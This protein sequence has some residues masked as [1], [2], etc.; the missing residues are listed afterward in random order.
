MDLDPGLSFNF[1]FLVMDGT[2]QK[3]Q[4]YLDFKFPYV[5][6]PY[7]GVPVEEGQSE[8]QFI[9]IPEEFHVKVE[10]FGYTNREKGSEFI[11]TQWLYR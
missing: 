6:F 7:L 8:H 4:Y 1:P 11:T 9:G 5:K 10:D 2:S 3:R